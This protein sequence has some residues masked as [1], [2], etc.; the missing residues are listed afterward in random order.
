MSKK[1]TRTAAALTAIKRDLG[2]KHTQAVRLLDKLHQSGHAVVVEGESAYIVDTTG[3]APRRVCTVADTFGRPGRGVA[4]LRRR[5]EMA[6]AGY[7]T[8]PAVDL[9]RLQPQI[10]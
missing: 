10:G 9:T 7:E 4:A 8:V 6:A 3:P 2:A 1:S 5:T